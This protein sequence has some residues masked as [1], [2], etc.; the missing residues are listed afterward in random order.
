MTFE[1]EGR[2]IY[3]VYLSI[4]VVVVVAVNLIKSGLPCLLAPSK[5][6]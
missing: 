5:K 3:A 2:K 6:V 4:C 1:K